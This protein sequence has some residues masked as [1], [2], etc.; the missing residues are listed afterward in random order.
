ML[1]VSGGDDALGKRKARGAHRVDEELHLREEPD[2][3]LERVIHALE[4][5][6]PRGPVIRGKG[7][8]RIV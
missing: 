7:S 4:D 5:F 6:V 1:Q 2:D 3:A 8:L